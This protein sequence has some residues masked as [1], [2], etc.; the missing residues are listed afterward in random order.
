MENQILL[1]LDFGGQY[2][3]LIARSVRSCGVYSLIKPGQITAK[4]VR[5]INPIGIILTGGPKSVY[6]ENAIAIDPEIFGL[7]IPILGI[8][9]GMQLL[10]HTFGGKVE[11][12]KKSEYGVTE[13]FLNAEN[14]LFK[15][16][17][18]AAKTLMSHTDKVTAL[19]KGFVGL[20]NTHNTEYAACADAERKLYGI[21]FH[22]EV[23][24]TENGTEIIRNFLYNI[25]AA[26]GDYNIDDY[27]ERQIELVRQKVGNEKIILALSGGVDSSVCA[28]I[29]SR[30]VGK[31]LIC[32]FVDHGFMRLNEGDDIERIFSAMDLQFIRVNAEER[33]LTQLE[34]V[35]EP[36]KK[37]KIIGEE[38]IRVFEEEARKLGDVT[39]LAQ[40]TI[41]PDIIESGGANAAIIKSHHNV[42]GLPKNI[43]FNA[44]IEPLSGL[45]KNEVREIGAKLGL[46][47]FLVSR[48]P[49]PGPGLAIRV[50][51]TLDKTKLNILRL[52]DNIVCQE[53]KKSKL[54][55]S[56][57]FAV[58][59]GVNTVG[60]MGDERSYDNLIA[61]RA[62]TTSDFMTCDYTPL[63]H[64][65]LK[66]ISARIVN[67]VKGVNRVVY[68]I[69]SKPPATVEWE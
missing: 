58:F 44:I 3:E 46:K 69:T 6:K 30:A 12:A 37:R 62:V 51:G 10:C 25:C 22:P 65:I 42:G 29:L 34:G 31:Q 14:E 4:K 64:R 1:V 13:T 17:K 68:D 49:F 7:G 57:Y 33:F 61:V 67:E 40:G 59:T 48:Q 2:K 18:T 54:K 15:G 60:V 47:K 28:A 23:E 8:C 32:V 53:I 24:L 52:A 5:E 66:K 41:Y 36:E 43:K 45:F 19:P 27:V 20:A 11:S 16:L 21:Q 56:Q 55:V 35:F 63:P 26:A 9:Y 39:F 38:F 50:M